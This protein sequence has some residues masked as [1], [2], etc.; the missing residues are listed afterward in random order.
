MIRDQMTH[1]VQDLPAKLRKRRKDY[2]PIRQELDK[3]GIKSQIHYLAT[4][5]VWKRRQKL[6]FAGEAQA[7]LKISFPSEDSSCC[8][9]WAVLWTAQIEDSR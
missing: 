4:L 9:H 2:L 6:K 5:W 8:A 1:F 3:R 7:I